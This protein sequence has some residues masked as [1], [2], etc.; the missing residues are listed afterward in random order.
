MIWEALEV[1]VDTAMDELVATGF[2]L[3]LDF[4]TLVNDLGLAVGDSTTGDKHS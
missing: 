4:L 3:N 1:N 2:L